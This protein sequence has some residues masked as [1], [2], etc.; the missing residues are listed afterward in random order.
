MQKQKHKKYFSKGTLGQSQACRKHAEGQEGPAEPGK[1][2]LVCGRA[3]GF[4][5]QALVWA[6]K[7][8]STS[9]HRY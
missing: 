3:A 6:R 1:A 7:C 2:S 4:V 5:K 8:N 9:N